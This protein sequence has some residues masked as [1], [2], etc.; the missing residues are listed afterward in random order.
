MLE[1]EI[2]ELLAK[3]L[4]TRGDTVHV[5]TLADVIAFDT[6][7]ADREMPLFGQELFEQAQTKGR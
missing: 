5:H 3:Y 1:T 2:K 7:H 4:A 6:A